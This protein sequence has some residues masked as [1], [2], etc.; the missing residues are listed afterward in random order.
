MERAKATILGIVWC[1]VLYFVACLLVGAVAGAIAGAADAG[2]GSAAAARAG[3]AAVSAYRLIIFI[4]AVA[5]IGSWS[6]VL[7]GTKRNKAVPMDGA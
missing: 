5:V 7:P 2:N 3:T 1:V 4:G 6:G